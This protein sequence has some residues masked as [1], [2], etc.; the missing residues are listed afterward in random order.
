[1]PLRHML[2]RHSLIFTLTLKLATI[3]HIAFEMKKLMLIE[4]LT[5]CN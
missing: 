4:T 3:K 5:L 2:F 1:M